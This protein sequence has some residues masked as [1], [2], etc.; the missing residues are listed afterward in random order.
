MKGGVKDPGL[1]GMNDPGLQA[2]H[3]LRVAVEIFSKQ[4]S[5]LTPEQFKIA[6]ERA[7]MALELE[8]L[9][10]LS[11]PA[12]RISV[13]LVAV[14]T[15]FDQVRS[16]YD[17]SASFE[18]AMRDGGLSQD[19][20]HRALWREL[21]FDAV[22]NLMGN[23]DDDADALTDEDVEAFYA[24]NPKRFQ[25]PE[26]RTARHI[27]ITINPQ[28]PD[29]TPEVARARIEK[30]SEE[31]A[32]HPENFAYLAE[33]NSECP[34]ALEGGLLGRTLQG[35]L[36]PSVD[37]VLFHLPE[38]G[39]GGPVESEAGLHLVLCE[40]IE[41]ATAIPLADV[42]EK[43]RTYLNGQRRKAKQKAWL[44]TLKT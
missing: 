27:L 39:V 11:A 28:Y 20:L 35:K 26:V 18:A 41:P 19:D 23:G 3:V 12:A 43:I 1:Q 33:K 10:L 14:D 42:R 32:A 37:A 40:K 9:V 36:Y 30:L 15:A 44:E 38:G 2:Y 34:S 25:K 29:N 6:R 17:D 24:N 4:P 5:E 7:L 22:M 31:L 21:T 16:R 13:P 8:D